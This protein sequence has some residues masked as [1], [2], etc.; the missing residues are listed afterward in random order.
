L[1]LKRIARNR[2]RTC[3]L[4]GILVLTLAPFVVATGYLGT[5]ALYRMTHAAMD[6]AAILEYS[7]L[8]VAVVIILLGLLVWATASPSG[9]SANARL[10]AQIGALPPAGNDLAVAQMLEELAAQAGVRPPKLYIVPCGIPVTL[11]GSMSAEDTMLALSRGLLDLLDPA[12]LQAFLAHEL[13][14]IANRDLQLKESLGMVSLFMTLPFKFFRSKMNFEITSRYQLYLRISLLLMAFT[15]VGIYFFFVGPL[16]GFVL[17]RWISRGQEYDADHDACSL[18]ENPE[19]L[20]CGLA[21]IK[22]ASYGIREMHP[23]FAR[24][25]ATDPQT[26]GQSFEA[27]F[28]ADRPA[29]S[30]RIQHLAQTRGLVSVSGL[31]QAIQGG[32][33]Y[34]K[35][36]PDMVDVTTHLP[37]EGDALSSLQQGD[38][39]GCV[40]RLAS[41]RQVPVYERP[42]K[43][44]FV[45]AKLNPGELLVAFDNPGEMRQVNTAGEVFGYVERNAKFERVPGVLPQEIYD[46][47][48]RAAVVR[49]LAAK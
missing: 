1:H 4:L 17:R 6:R 40:Y 22:A 27:R 23:L 48:S 38:P 24:S 43:R 29:H 18:T 12:Q 21:K 34:A 10:L 26:V 20:I 13:S 45:I 37:G 9:G 11:S 2:T 25:C 19:P 32:K 42:N 5:S 8:G 7:P 36:H 47:V 15:P 16:V 31:E 3:V 44:S 46:P 41:P 30:S 49:T 33:E 14:H 35:M 39:M 28:L